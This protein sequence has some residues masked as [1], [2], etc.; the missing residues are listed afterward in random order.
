MPIN[1]QHD[2]DE[3][4]EKILNKMGDELSRELNIKIEGEVKN[5]LDK[6]YLSSLKCWEKVLK[7][8]THLLQNYF[9]DNIF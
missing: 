8:N 3:F 4:L 6:I 9:M 2:V 1:Y 5:E 7:K